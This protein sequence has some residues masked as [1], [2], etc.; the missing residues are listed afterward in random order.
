MEIATRNRRGAIANATPLAPSQ[1]R[2]SPKNG[3]ST[4]LDASQIELTPLASGL[5]GSFDFGEDYSVPVGDTVTYDIDYFL[6]FDPAPVLLGGGLA[7]DPWGMDGQESG[8][9]R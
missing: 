4:V 2:V 1:S 8:G 7:L 9:G 5:G 6:L 3:S